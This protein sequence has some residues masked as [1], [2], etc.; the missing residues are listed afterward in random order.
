MINGYFGN[1]LHFANLYF[2]NSKLKLEK[3]KNNNKSEKYPCNSWQY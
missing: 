2:I 1:D 3:E